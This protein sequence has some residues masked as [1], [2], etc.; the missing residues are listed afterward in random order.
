M[1]CFAKSW[2]CLLVGLILV[3]PFSFVRAQ[4][5]SAGECNSFECFR[6]YTAC[7]PIK[8]VVEQLNSDANDIGLQRQAIIN[9][10]ESRLR[11]ARIY[12]SSASDYLYVNIHV[13]GKAFAIRLEL[14]KMLLDLR[15][16]QSRPAKTWHTGSTG[17]HGG[18]SQYILGSLSKHLDAFLTEFLRVNEPACDDT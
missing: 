6:L 1:T 15:T 5:E 7:E 2:G 4:T 10:A 18:D 14:N 12:D 17:T 3:M 11:S 9:A 8:L 13:A 16:I